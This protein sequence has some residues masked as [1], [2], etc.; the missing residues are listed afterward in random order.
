MFVIQM[1]K[2]SA[3]KVVTCFAAQA[4]TGKDGISAVVGGSVGGVLLLVVVVVIVIV[5]LKR[6]SVFFCFSYIKYKVMTFITC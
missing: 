3:F 6:R 1:N 4:A 5:I 2:T